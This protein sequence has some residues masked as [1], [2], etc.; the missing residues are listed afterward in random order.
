MWQ[1]KNK[2]NLYLFGAEAIH[3]HKFP[4][5]KVP[6]TYMQVFLAEDLELGENCGSLKGGGLKLPSLIR[7][8]IL[9]VCGCCFLKFSLKY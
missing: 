8:L 9:L 6:K 3:F 4:S 1:V 2:S 7:P 5:I